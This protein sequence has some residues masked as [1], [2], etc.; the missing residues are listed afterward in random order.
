MADGDTLAAGLLSES[1]DPHPDADPL[2]DDWEAPPRVPSVPELH[3][4]GFDGPLDLLLDLAERARIDLARLSIGAVIE[5]FV[6]AMA[7]YERHVPIER[8]ADWLVL[9]SR[10][11]VLRSRLLFAADAAAALEAEQ[12]AAREL[13]RLRDL[14]FVRAAAAWLK[15]RPQLGRDVFARPSRER[16]PRVASYMKLME[17]CLT[18]L[19]R[20]EE[21]AAEAPGE[22]EPVY[23]PVARLLFRVPD[24]LAR[25]RGVL[26]RADGPVAFRQCLPPV[27]REA[28]HSELRARSAVASTLI[29]ALEL[30]RAGEAGL[31]GAETVET[32]TLTPVA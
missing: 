2:W 19:E 3:V 26:S 32:L 10:L 29:A 4:D 5:Q 31:N 1:P 13:H 14:Q 30:A 11:L 21:T 27:D 28:A 6:R 9:A 22:A 17:A 12:A 18:L 25:V 20:E 16:D 15:A 8:R 7:R 23:R 24:A